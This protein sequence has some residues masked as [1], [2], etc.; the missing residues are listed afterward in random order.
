M[1]KQEE[2]Q[3]L[4]EEVKPSVVEVFKRELLMEAE[5]RAR[6]AAE[7]VIV[8][9]IKKVMAEE[10]LPEITK[11]ILESKEGL[12]S[13]GARIADEMAQMLAEAFTNELSDK[14]NNSWERR[15]ILR[16]LLGEY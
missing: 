8:E 3:K 6:E 12:I 1:L 10:V 2:I 5:E 15:K 9:H 14:L 11:R 4:I 16:A 13:I 7:Q